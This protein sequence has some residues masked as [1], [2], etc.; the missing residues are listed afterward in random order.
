MLLNVLFHPNILKQIEFRR[1][2]EL[3][4]KFLKLVK[5]ALSHRDK[6]IIETNGETA[7]VAVSS[8]CQKLA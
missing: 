3:Q 5:N 6:T 2:H 7:R 4:W 8:F 1:F